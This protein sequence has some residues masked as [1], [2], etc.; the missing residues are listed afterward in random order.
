MRLPSKW[1]ALVSGKFYRSLRQD[2]CLNAKLTHLPPDSPL[3]IGRIMGFVG[4]L[5]VFTQTFWAAKAIRRFGPHRIFITMFS[6][7]PFSFLVYPFLNYFA[8]KAGRV[9]ATVI[10]LIVLQ[11]SASFLIF[12]TYGAP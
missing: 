9:D 2:A 11:M 12:P 3:Y 8:R 7:L 4:F 6:Y 10:A 5:N 1:V